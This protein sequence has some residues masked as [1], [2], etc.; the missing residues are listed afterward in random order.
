MSLCCFALIK[1][2]Y[3]YNNICSIVLYNLYEL[4]KNSEKIVI[5]VLIQLFG[6]KR[7]SIKRLLEEVLSISV[8]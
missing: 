8:I 5:I 3:V 6:F 7:G 1:V 4:Y 2:F